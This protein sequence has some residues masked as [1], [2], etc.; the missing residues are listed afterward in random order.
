MAWMVVRM[1]KLWL[2]Q[3][4][5]AAY[6]RNIR[7]ISERSIAHYF[8][9]LKWISRYL[10]KK[11]LIQDSIFEIADLFQLLSLKAVLFSDPEFK[12]LNTRGHQMYSAGLNNYMRFAN[13]HDFST[14]STKLT[15]LDK[16]M[17]IPE[18]SSDERN[19]WKRS[20]IIR[21][22]VLKAAEYHCE[23]D[24][25]HKTFILN[26][27]HHPYA[28]GHHIIALKKQ[29]V[30]PRSLDIYAN[31]IC[32]CPVCHRFLHYG[33]AQDK[34]PVIKMIYSQRA[35][36]LAKSGIKLSQGEFEHLVL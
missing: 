22:Q 27:T 15:L 20:A 32:L 19:T 23:I 5:Y 7:Q 29:N 2:M 12:E 3:E 10:C 25:A 8:D 4:Y 35:D 18:I 24:P 17:P 13:A 33:T 31:I 9:A 34:R 16:P 14:L 28:E 6:L 21:D 36:R 30:V 11:G 1:D 26:R